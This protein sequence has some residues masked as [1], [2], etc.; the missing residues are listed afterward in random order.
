MDLINAKTQRLLEGYISNPSGVLLVVDQSNSFPEEIMQY[1]KKKLISQ[2][3]MAN[4]IIVQPVKNTISIEQMRELKKSLAN[5]SDSTSE[6]SRFV[7]L[8]SIE[9]ATNQAQNAILKLIEEP[10]SNTLVL[11]HTSSINKVLQ[12]IVSRCKVLH[13]LPI[14]VNQA[15]K[16]G[17]ILGSSR[18]EINKAFQISAGNAQIFTEIVENNESKT[19]EKIKQ[20]KVFIGN[21]VFDRL[22]QQNEYAQKEEFNSLLDGLETISVAALHT[23]KGKGINRWK[24]IVNEVRTC[25]ELVTENVSIKL[26][27]LR[28][29]T[30]I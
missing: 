12:T 4:Q 21:T 28:L 25:K 2:G 5:K 14:S 9:K 15:Y 23:S 13:V 22:S 19:S 26:V 18:T 8:D 20:A 30:N 24:N 27:F 16:Y 7:R 3:N 11:L 6:F 10:P 1:L 29:S 17:E